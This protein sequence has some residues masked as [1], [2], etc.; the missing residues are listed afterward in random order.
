MRGLGS[1]FIALYLL[2]DQR[3]EYPEEAENSFCH[4]KLSSDDKQTSRDKSQTFKFRTTI[5]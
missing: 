3:G 1:Q 5:L 2:D 4:S